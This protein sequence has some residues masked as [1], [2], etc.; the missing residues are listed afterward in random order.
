MV[1]MRFLISADTMS[2]SRPD[3]SSL[4]EQSLLELLVQD[5]DGISE[6][7]DHHGDFKSISRWRGV[8]CGEE[9]RVHRIDWGNILDYAFGCEIDCGPLNPG[10]SIDFQWIP[11]MV[12][13]FNICRMGLAGSIETAHLPGGLTELHIGENR[14]TGL[15]V[16]RDLP[17]NIEVVDVSR[18]TLNGSLDMLSMPR[19]MREFFANNNNFSGSAELTRLPETLSEL[20]L[21][22]NKFSGV[23]DLSTLPTKLEKLWLR[24]NQF[25]QEVLTVGRIPSK[26][27]SIEWKN[28]ASVQNLGG[29]SISH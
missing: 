4:P 6:L 1:T 8:M 20:N 14:I 21:S 15:F 9:E 29:A 12:A 28:F 17:R 11:S 16:M 27:M 26:R 13:Y 18:N 10:G 22:N 24:N 25:K 19:G 23:L 5:F 3:P 7:K 2:M